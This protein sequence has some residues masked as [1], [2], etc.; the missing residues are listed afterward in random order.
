MEWN[1]GKEAEARSVRTFFQRASALPDAAAAAGSALKAAGC[2]C[3]TV[4][5]WRN[6]LHRRASD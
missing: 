5:N 2:G 1:V 3:W 4:E 6:M